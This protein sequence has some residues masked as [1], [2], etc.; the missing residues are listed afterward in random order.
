MLG[1]PF[2][3]SSKSVVK[4]NSATH[5]YLW[6]SSH[7]SWNLKLTTFRWQSQRLAR[8]HFRAWWEKHKSF[9]H[10]NTTKG[11][12]SNKH[13]PL[14]GW[15]LFCNSNSN[16]GQNLTALITWQKFFEHA[17]HVWMAPL[18][19]ISF[20]PPFPF[21]FL[22]PPRQLRFRCTCISGID[23]VDSSP[24]ASG[25]PWNPR[26][27]CNH[28]AVQLFGNSSWLSPIPIRC[29]GGCNELRNL[30]GRCGCDGADNGVVEKC[31]GKWKT[32]SGYMEFN[33]MMVR[34]PMYYKLNVNLLR[35]ASNFKSHLLFS[36]GHINILPARAKELPSYFSTGHPFSHENSIFVHTNIF[37]SAPLLR[38]IFATVCSCVWLRQL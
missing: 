27:F 38:L 22:T 21:F 4:M 12:A 13:V 34:N 31:S 32:Q 15:K 10:Q 33:K 24:P 11:K 5:S 17:M 8:F 19:S 18:R 36:S 3:K 6:K 20:F 30:L 23:L 7:R 37:H 1:R 9:H 16:K 14:A 29:S 35:A 2:G 25:A 28:L 26:G